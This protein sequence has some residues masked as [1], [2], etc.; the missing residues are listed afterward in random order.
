MFFIFPCL[1]KSKGMGTG[2]YGRQVIGLLL[3]FH[4]LGNFA[5][6]IWQVRRPK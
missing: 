3:P 1:K 6:N 5:F 4:I 2:L